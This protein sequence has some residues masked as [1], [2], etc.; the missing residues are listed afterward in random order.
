MNGELLE[1]LIVIQIVKKF[2]EFYGTRRF[3]AVFT[4]AHHRSLF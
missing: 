1:K 3:I 4:T 2:Y